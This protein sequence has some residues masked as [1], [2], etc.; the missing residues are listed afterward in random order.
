MKVLLLPELM[1][2]LI[3]SFWKYTQLWAEFWLH[4]ASNKNSKSTTRLMRTVTE[5]LV[6]AV[7]HNYILINNVCLRC[8]TRSL[9]LSMQISKNV[10]FSCFPLITYWYFTFSRHCFRVS[11]E[12]I[13]LIDEQT[14]LYLE[15]SHHVNT[16]THYL[17]NMDWRHL[18][19]LPATCCTLGQGSCGASWNSFV[20]MSISETSVWT[21]IQ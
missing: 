3:D 1:H 2:R 20:P 11:T 16:P 14:K 15:S 7:L 21:Q 19:F 9:C 12:E 17:Y 18:R 5:A 6:F 8:C 13:I 4:V 10:F